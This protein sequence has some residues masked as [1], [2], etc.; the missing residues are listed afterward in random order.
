MKNRRQQWMTNTYF[1]KKFENI[2]NLTWT[3]AKLRAHL[4]RMGH[5]PGAAFENLKKVIVKTLLVA[6]PAF[7]ST[8]RAIGSTCEGCYQLLGVDVIFDQHLNPVVI[9]VN[10]LPSMQ[11]EQEKSLHFKLAD[12]DPYALTK[13]QLTQ[14]LVQ[15]LFHNQSILHDFVPN[16]SQS[17]TNGLSE[18][19]LRYLFMLCRELTKSG[20]FELL[21]PPLYHSHWWPAFLPL[22]AT[23]EKLSPGQTLTNQEL[24]YVLKSLNFE[25]PG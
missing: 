1:N 18:T 5:D 22:V 3:F 4:E 9:E 11:M 19:I 6:E 8:F 20:H 14:D 7:H 23:A 13:V 25:C 16:L 24:V 17:Q 2:K 12:D 21:Y 10:G 15:M